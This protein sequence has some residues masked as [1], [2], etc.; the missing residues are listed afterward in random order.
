VRRL[1]S[2]VRMSTTSPWELRRQVD[3]TV[4]AVLS[5][6]LLLGLLEGVI[7]EGR[8]LCLVVDLLDGYCLGLR[9]MI[10]MLTS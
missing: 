6:Q 1:V 7:P 3:P 2:K 8:V 5:A 4:H 10:K 9:W